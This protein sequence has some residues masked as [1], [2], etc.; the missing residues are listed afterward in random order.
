MPER[1]YRNK[2][3]YQGNG[4]PFCGVSKPKSEFLDKI[5]EMDD[6]ELYEKTKEMIWLSAYAA[7]NPR[8]DYHWQCDACYDEWMHRGKGQKYQQAWEYVAREN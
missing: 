2:D 1:E 3:Q 8:S 5:A 4:N 6:K 7:N